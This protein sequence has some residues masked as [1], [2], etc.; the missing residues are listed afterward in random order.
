VYAS[1]IAR[2]PPADRAG[3][4][5]RSV[6]LYGGDHL[7][8]ISDLFRLEPLAHHPPPRPSV[9]LMLLLLSFLAAERPVL[10][11]PRRPASEIWARRLPPPVS[12]RGYTP[13]ES[14][15]M[16]WLTAEVGLKFK[17]D[18]FGSTT[19][20]PDARGPY[21]KRPQK[22]A[23][24]PNMKKLLSLLPLALVAAILAPAGRRFG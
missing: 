16:E 22:P 13:T 15:P 6:A 11:Q 7:K 20:T 4:D 1:T 12:R 19:S 17:S 18:G 14:Y 8:P 10:R 9:T 23:R 21:P 24:N 3:W 5:V 2:D